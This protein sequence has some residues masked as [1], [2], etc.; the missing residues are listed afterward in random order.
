MVE[1]AQKVSDLLRRIVNAGRFRL[2]RTTR[3]NPSAIDA[4]GRRIR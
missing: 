2:V 4:E 1:H 3:D